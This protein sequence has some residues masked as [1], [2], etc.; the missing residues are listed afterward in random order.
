MENPLNIIGYSGGGASTMSP[1]NICGLPNGTGWDRY[2]C[3]EHL[4]IT[5]ATG[6]FG[7]DYNDWSSGLNRRYSINPRTV[8]NFPSYGVSWTDRITAY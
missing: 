8:I 1:S 3:G 4:H 7:V 6:L 2:T 5:V